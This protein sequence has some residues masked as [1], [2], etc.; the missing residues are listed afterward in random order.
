[1]TIEY[2]PVPGSRVDLCVSAAVKMAATADEIVVLTFN[3][4][5]I[6][7]HPTYERHL[8]EEWADYRDSLP[9]AKGADV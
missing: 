6:K 5:T 2:N 4:T 1:V 3:G 9:T 8:L 7:I